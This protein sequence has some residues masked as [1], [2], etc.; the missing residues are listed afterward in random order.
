MTNSV[1]GSE[2]DVLLVNVEYRRP[3][4]DSI[5]CSWSGEKD[6]IHSRNEGPYVSAFANE[7]KFC[8]V[9]KRTMSE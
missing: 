1:P 4:R 6:G 8:D 9:E 3:K 2:D 7:G 5:C